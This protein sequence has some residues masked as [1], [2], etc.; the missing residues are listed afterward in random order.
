MCQ[1][2]MLLLTSLYRFCIVGIAAV[3]SSLIC[4]G[5]IARDAGPWSFIATIIAVFLVCVVDELILPR[6]AQDDIWSRLVGPAI[7]GGIIG[8]CVGWAIVYLASG[9][10]K[11]T[12]KIPKEF[13]LF[14]TPFPVLCLCFIPLP[15]VWG[16][17]AGVIVRGISTWPRKRDRAE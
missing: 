6:P 11:A 4:A 3:T 10:M 9:M 12:G 14:S 15:S 7:R 13:V 16:A 17:V 2:S 1:K 5:L 8:L